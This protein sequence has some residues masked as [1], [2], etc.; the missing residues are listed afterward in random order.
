MDLNMKGLRIPYLNK[1]VME[2]EK[3]YRGFHIFQ[4]CTGKWIT[5]EHK[6]IDYD[7]VTHQ[8]WSN[9]Y[10]YHKYLICKIEKEIQL[11]R[12]IE[13]TIEF[14]LAQ[15]EYRFEGILLEWQPIYE[16]EKEW[17]A[18]QNTRKILTEK[19]KP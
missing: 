10:W 9:I 14:A 5:L 15:L 13:S 16:S 11:C 12:E 19:Y 18:E 1:L 8:H 7:D 3:T 6:M 17:Y 2:S 4:L